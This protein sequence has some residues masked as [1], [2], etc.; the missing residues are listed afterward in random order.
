MNDS[1]YV[2]KICQAILQN[3]SPQIKEDDLRN[4]IQIDSF[5]EVIRQCVSLLN[6]L[7][8]SL[9]RTTY[10]GE[11]YFVLTTPGKDE[12]VSPI[13]YGILISLLALYKEIGQSI[14]EKDLKK[15]FDD[16][17]ND[18]LMLIENGYLEIQEI[19][20]K[21]EVLITPIGKA[22]CKNIYNQIDLK[23]ILNK[24]DKKE[25]VEK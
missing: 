8:Y 4:L 7:G 3:N 18:C 2:K 5:D 6:D 21:K 13:M 24:I 22:A 16:V 20:G 15:I 23:D 11:K 14:T 19:Q 10:N 12:R 25:S 17:W 9:I 1:K